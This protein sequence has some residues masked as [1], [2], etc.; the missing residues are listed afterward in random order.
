MSNDLRVV[1]LGEN[2]GARVDGVRLGNS[3]LK[4]RP[5]ITDTRTA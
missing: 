2:I 1:K 4:P 3:M 5:P